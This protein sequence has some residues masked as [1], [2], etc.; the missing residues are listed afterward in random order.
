MHIFSRAFKEASA[1]TDRSAAH[2]ILKNKTK[3]KM[4]SKTEDAGDIQQVKVQLREELEEVIV[5][6]NR[7]MVSFLCIKSNKQARRGSYRNVSGK[8]L[9]IHVS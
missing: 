7:S 3:F 8:G 1:S 2:R 5:E 4:A 9:D 6:R